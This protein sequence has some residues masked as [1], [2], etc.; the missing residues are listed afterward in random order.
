MAERSTQEATSIS[1]V[2]STGDL[3]STQEALSISAVVPSAIAKFHGTQEA[4]L[5]SVTAP[6]MGITYPVSPPAI[7][8]IGPLDFTLSEVHVVGETESPFTLGQ[9]LQQWQG[10]AWDLEIN[11][12]PM[13]LVQAEQWIAFLGSLL[14]KFGTFLMGDYNRPTPQGPMSGSPVSSGSANAPGLNQLNVR[15]ASN[16]I[17]NWAVAGDYIQLTAAGSPQRLYKVLQNASTDSSGNVTLQIF[18]NIR[19][20]IPDGTTIITSNCRGTFRLME[21][22]QP[23]KVD[24]NKLYTIS[25]KAKEAI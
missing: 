13:L 1:A 8:G 11:L 23:W 20:N 18:P 6:I 12:P 24:R 22:K 19:E 4:T 14:G 15:G 5:I 21:N 3:R 10:Q 16:S 9:Q 2:V 25:F 7:S 17:T